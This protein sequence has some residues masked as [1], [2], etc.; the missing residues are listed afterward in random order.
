MVWKIFWQMSELHQHK[1]RLELAEITG[2]ILTAGLK[3]KDQ[4]VVGSKEM[5]LP[6]FMVPWAC[7]PGEA[8]A[9]LQHFLI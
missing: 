9:V 2:S 4:G 5:I 7:K 6:H 3:V 1:G 8:E